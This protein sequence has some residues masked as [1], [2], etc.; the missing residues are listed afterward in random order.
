MKIKKMLLGILMIVFSSALAS[1]VLVSSASGNSGDTFNID[2]NLVRHHDFPDLDWFAFPENYQLDLSNSSSICPSNDCKGN[3]RF[4]NY[5]T[6]NYSVSAFELSEDTN[7]MV[8]SADF[9]LVD[10]VSNGHFTPKKQNLIEQMSFDWA[11]SF[12]D[13]QEDI[14]KNTTK[15]ICS[16]PE[17]E[18]II[19]KFNSTGYPYTITATFELPSRRLVLNATEIHGN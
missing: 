2:V 8:M 12:S 15:Y 19:R 9:R 16:N 10:D 3:L 1:S 14:K 6:L 17:N 13:I 7:S 5:S 4:S 18:N 11:C